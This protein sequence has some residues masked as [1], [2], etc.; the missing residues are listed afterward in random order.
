MAVEVENSGQLEEL[1]AIVRRRSAWVLYPV[2]LFVTIGTCFAVIV[3]KKYVC[4]TR[5]LVRN[6]LEGRS[7]T[8]TNSAEEARMAAHQ[9]R[10]FPRIQGVLLTLGWSDYMN[11]PPAERTKYEK[12]VRADVDVDVPNMPAGTSDQQIVAISYSNTNPTRAKDFLEELTG[13]WKEEVLEQ[14]RNAQRTAWEKLKSTKNQLQ[15]Q[16]DEAVREITELRKAYSIPVDTSGQSSS[17]YDSP[18]DPTFL[19]LASLV[20]EREELDLEI[21]KLETTLATDRD[22]LA[23][24]PLTISEVAVEGSVENEAKIAKLGER[25]FQLQQKIREN[26]YKPDH[27]KYERT[28]DEIRALQEE[29]RF[30]ESTESA[31]VETDSRTPNPRRAELEAKIAEA[32][33]ELVAHKQRR[34]ELERRVQDRRDRANELQDVYAEIRSL[35]A[36]VRQIDIELED[37][38]VRLAKQ[39]SDYQ[40]VQGPGGD[41]FEVLEDIEMPQ[42][43]SEPNPILIVAFAL[44][45][46]GGLGLG[47]AAL[48]EFGKSVYR[49]V[50]DVGRVMVVPVLGTINTI[51]IQREIRR[52]RLS[53]LLV[54][55]LTFGLISILSYITWAWKVNPQLLSP[56]VYDAI[57][58]FRATFE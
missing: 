13:R 40:W 35:E 53:R 44:F 10:A 16:R 37:V 7:S 3:P 15:G 21:L 55:G 20:Q 1:L 42:S 45:L 25:I 5:I 29:I 51:H 33:R 23:A 28:Q 57:E 58:G 31:G 34:S 48:T 12:R 49:S 39:A 36:R 27:P 26:G 52:R 9:I 43:P 8:Q 22:R 14:G 24:E 18:T 32:E 11:Q 46:G 56:A 17:R 54:G 47:M 19:D 30:L 2:A 6:T 4:E 41:P 38:G 50:S